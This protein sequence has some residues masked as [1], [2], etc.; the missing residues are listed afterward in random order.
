MKPMAGFSPA[1]TDQPPAAYSIPGALTRRLVAGIQS[2]NPSP[3]EKGACVAIA[4]LEV[5]HLSKSFHSNRLRGRTH[6]AVDDV[7]LAIGPD[8]LMG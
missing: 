8:K 1:F 6:K 3:V 5:Q 4:T 2:R 7:S